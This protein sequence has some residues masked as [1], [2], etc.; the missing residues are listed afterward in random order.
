MIKNVCLISDT[1]STIV[2]FDGWY[3][4]VLNMIMGEDIRLTSL[5]TNVEEYMASDEYKSKTVPKVELRYD[6]Y[7]D[8]VIEKE[9]LIK[10][11]VIIPQNNIRFSIINIIAYICGNLVNKHMLTFT[12][13]A[14]TYGEDRKCLLYFKNEFLFSRALLTGVKK[15]YATNWELQEGVRI[16]QTQD[17]SLDIKGMPINKS[18]MNKAAKNR[19]QT[20]LYNDILRADH[21]DQIKILEKIAIFEKEIKESLQSGSKDYFK[22]ARI[23]AM[24]SYADPMRIQGVK[25]AVI[26]N[27]IKDPE[28]EEINLDAINTISIAKVKIDPTNVGL[29]KDKYP[30]AYD[31]LCSLLSNTTFFGKNKPVIECVGLPT[32]VETPEWLMDFIDY[33]GIINDN[34]GNFPFESININRMEVKN[35]NYSM[36]MKL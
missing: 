29:I 1:D 4:F 22:P 3:H 34:V 7:T 32:D 27:K 18:V 11:F 6:F 36:M 5:E 10:P 19:L 2:S 9:S 25:A 28:L 26:W 8:E 17:H 30:A 14:H 21:I 12:K 23:K 20:I 16:E 13:S 33:N 35:V 31:R 24:E 15:N